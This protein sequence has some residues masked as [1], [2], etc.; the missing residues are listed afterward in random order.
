M[1]MGAPP[2]EPPATKSG[3]ADC[4]SNRLPRPGQQ[5]DQSVEEASNKSTKVGGEGRSEAGSQSEPGAA[6]PGGGGAASQKGRPA[7]REAKE[8]EERE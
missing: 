2:H 7:V 4:A 5:L 6:G 1:L 8:G 3:R